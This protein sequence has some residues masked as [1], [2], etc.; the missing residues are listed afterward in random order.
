MSRLP[1]DAFLTGL[2]N[3]VQSREM[4]RATLHAVTGLPLPRLADLIRADHEPYLDEAVLLQRCLGLSGVRYLMTSGNLTLS[5]L[6]LGVPLPDDLDMLRAGVRL[7][8]SLACRVALKLGLDDPSELVVSPRHRQIWDVLSLNERG[9]PSTV[10]TCPWC[11]AQ[12]REEGHLPTCLPHNLW[13]PRERS[14]APPNLSV[15]P[16]PA[17]P[18]KSRRAS[19]FAKGLRRE[20]EAFGVKQQD[21]ATVIGIRPDYLCKI[22]NGHLTLTVER[23]TEI[24]RHLQCD[25]A[26]LYREDLPDDATSAADGAGSEAGTD[27]Q[28][29]GGEA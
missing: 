4:T 24:A 29:K 25:V 12:V 6:N 16:R 2:R 22:E 10:G 28:T 23:A 1:H 27:A 7:P 21:L 19:G 9:H 17:A 3:I 13:G 5:S 20:R 18:G 14:V 11:C 15:L 26:A 8:L